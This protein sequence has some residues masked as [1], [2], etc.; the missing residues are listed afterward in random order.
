M[1]HFVK[2]ARTRWNWHFLSVNW[3][4]HIFS[5]GTGALVHRSNQSARKQCAWKKI[6]GW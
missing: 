4:L 5:W 6:L 1:S 3:F 2:M